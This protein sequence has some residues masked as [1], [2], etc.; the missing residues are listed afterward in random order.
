MAK[1]TATDLSFIRTCIRPR[2]LGIVQTDG[3]NASGTPF[4]L[5]AV[6]VSCVV[7]AIF[8]N[9]F[10]SAGESA[11]G[12]ILVVRDRRRLPRSAHVPF[13]LRGT[14]VCC[15]FPRFWFAPEKNPVEGHKGYLEAESP[16]YG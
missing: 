6:A 8:S 11:G 2:V 3:V 4:C 10:L 16:Q 9:A 13:R 14:V 15:A 1:L 5:L 12:V 7:M